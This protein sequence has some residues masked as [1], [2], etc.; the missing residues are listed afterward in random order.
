[1][2]DTGGSLVVH[3][4]GLDGGDLSALKLGTVVDRNWVK[5]RYVCA[6]S[7]SGHSQRDYI[8]PASSFNRSVGLQRLFA[9]RRSHFPGTQMGEKVEK[10]PDGVRYYRLSEI[11]QQNSFKS[12]WFIIHNKV[13]DV[14]KFLEEVRFSFRTFHFNIATVATSAEIFHQRRQTAAGGPQS[15]LTSLLFVNRK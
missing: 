9:L 4:G 3:R 10:S 2:K 12:T 13:Y 7:R 11:E 1:M 15:H 14:T 6:E 8:N 5:C